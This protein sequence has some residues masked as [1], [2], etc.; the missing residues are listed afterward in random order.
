M[1]VK[2]HRMAAHACH[3]SDSSTA[4]KHP[5][6]C[7]IPVLRRHKVP[8]PEARPK[9]SCGAAW[10]FEHD[11]PSA[12]MMMLCVLLSVCRIF[13]ALTHAPSRRGEPR[14]LQQRPRHRTAPR[15][16][17]LVLAQRMRRGRHLTQGSGCAA[18]QRPAQTQPQ[19]ATPI[20]VCLDILFFTKALCRRRRRSIGCQKP[21]FSRHATS[22]KCGQM[23]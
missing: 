10:I 11:V 20:Q 6:C 14:C 16:K 1:A 17:H 5:A 23:R 22:T 3:Y 13:Q 8:S 21:L 19:L 7:S 18:T 15:C 12:P 2:C 4:P 9:S